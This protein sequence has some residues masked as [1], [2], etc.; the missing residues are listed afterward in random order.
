MQQRWPLLNRIGRQGSFASCRSI[1]PVGENGQI[2]HT[3]KGTVEGRMEFQRKFFF[4][5]LIL[6]QHRYHAP[7]HPHRIAGTMIGC[8]AAFEGCRRILSPAW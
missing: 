7:L 6:S 1:D 5:A 3:E 4:G 2:S 8:M